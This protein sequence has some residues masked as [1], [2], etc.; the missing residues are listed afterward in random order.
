MIELAQDA[1]KAAA[2]SNALLTVASPIRRD[3][4][5]L[6]YRQHRHGSEASIASPTSSL[7]RTKTHP[8]SKG[9]RCHSMAQAR[10]GASSA[11]SAGCSRPIL[12]R[13]LSANCQEPL[14]SEPRLW[15]QHAHSLNR[16]SLM[17]VVLLLPLL[18]LLHPR[19]HLWHPH[20]PDQHPC[21]WLLVFLVAAMLGLVPLR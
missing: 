14:R 13:R 20:W 6:H 5:K 1:N 8:L 19:L 15:W 3:R 9:T 18:R 7:S 2:S 21:S 17:V 11:A 10:P 4:P 16:T 12:P